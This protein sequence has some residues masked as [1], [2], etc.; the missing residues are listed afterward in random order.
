MMPGTSVTS[1]RRCVAMAWSLSPYRAAGGRPATFGAAG[2]D[3]CRPSRPSRAA[4]L[5]VSYRVPSYRL[6][7][8][9]RAT[10]PSAPPAPRLHRPL[11]PLRPVAPFDRREVA[12]HL[13]VGARGQDDHQ[14]GGAAEKGGEQAEV[15]EQVRGVQQENDRRVKTLTGDVYEARQRNNPS[16]QDIVLAA[17]ASRRVVLA[18]SVLIVQ[19]Q[20]CA[21]VNDAPPRAPGR[22]RGDAERERQHGGGESNNQ[23]LHDLPP[24]L[25][26]PL[27]SPAG[28]SSRP[29]G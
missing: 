1:T 28:A 3:G 15:E 19:Q 12:P 26:T 2:T 23:T 6:Q 10:P 21:N 8:H 24:A 16:Y 4:N 5:P 11:P 17:S 13:P 9:S 25:H 20:L 29:P 18:R 22:R 14:Q 27:Q 7:F